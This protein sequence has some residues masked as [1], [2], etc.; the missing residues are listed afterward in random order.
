MDSRAG[1]SQTKD[2]ARPLKRLSLAKKDGQ[3]GKAKENTS[4]KLSI[5]SFFK[6]TPPSKLACPLCGKRIPRY[7]INEHIDSQCRDFLEEK[8]L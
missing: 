3:R 8:D 1:R 5:T 2:H 4:N 7:K 6:N